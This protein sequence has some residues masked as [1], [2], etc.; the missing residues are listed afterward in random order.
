[1]APYNRQTISLKVSYFYVKPIMN[2][3]C[4]KTKKV[5]DEIIVD[6]LWPYLSR[7]LSYMCF[8]RLKNG[9]VNH[10]TLAIVY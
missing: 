9:A 2:N 5:I 10:I 8:N 4:N 6:L 1:M 3:I 7:N